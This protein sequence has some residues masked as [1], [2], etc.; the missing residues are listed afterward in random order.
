MRFINTAYYYYYYIHRHS[1]ESYVWCLELSGQFC[2]FYV[3]KVCVAVSLDYALN[4]HWA[5]VFGK[6]RVCFIT[7]DVCAT[8][9]QILS[10][11]LLN[12]MSL[13][14]MNIYD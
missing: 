14:Y 7:T 3:R 4:F 8:T 2:M 6:R 5:A 10:L 9:I 1:Y 11:F 13:P 12:K